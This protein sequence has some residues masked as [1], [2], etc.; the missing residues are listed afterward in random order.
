MPVR[1]TRYA[2]C[3]TRVLRHAEARNVWIRLR[4]EGDELQLDARFLL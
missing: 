4:V 3:V 1:R 2:G